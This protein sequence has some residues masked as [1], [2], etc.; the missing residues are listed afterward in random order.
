[1]LEF[2]WSPGDWTSMNLMKSMFLWFCKRSTTESLLIPRKGPVTALFNRFKH[3]HFALRITIF[4]AV[5]SYF[6]KSSTEY[7]EPGVQC[8]LAVPG[9]E[10][11]ENHVVKE[12]DD[13]SG[14]QPPRFSMTSLGHF[15]L[16]ICI[17]VQGP[18]SCGTWWWRS[19]AWAPQGSSTPSTAVTRR[20]RGFKMSKLVWYLR[21][22][23]LTWFHH[24]KKPKLIQS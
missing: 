14:I 1:M 17:E 13:G 22:A 20:F 21:M 10:P 15:A 16:P 12:T 9:G 3:R 11:S 6:L 24:V 5:P 19:L 23:G 7:E 8:H 2:N 18:D 4:G